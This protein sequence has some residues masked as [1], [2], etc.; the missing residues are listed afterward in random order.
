MS[1]TLLPPLREYALQIDQRRSLGIAEFG[2]HE[3]FPVLWFPGTPGGRRQVP[4]DTRHYARENN[5]RIIC[6]ERPGIGFSTR[7][8]YDAISDFA[9]DIERV[10]EQLDIE[11]CGVVALSGGGPYAL[12]CAHA[13]SSRV[14]A[15]AVF[16]GV[17]PTLGEEAPEGGLTAKALPVEK[18]LTYMKWPLGTVLSRSVKMLHPLADPIVDAI[19]KY[20]PGHETAMIGREDIRAMFIDDILNSSK[21]GLHS[22]LHDIILFNRPWG[23]TLSGIAVPV[24]FWHGEE[25]PMVPPEHAEHMAGLITG[26]GFTICEDAGH[27]E[28]L[29]KTNEALEY[30]LAHARPPK[31]PGAKRA[32]KKAAPAS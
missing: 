25:D 19:V 31:K 6:V 17:A 14:V 13:L 24:H 27:L 5:I 22:I 21:A 9:R 11:R 15:T 12:A 3:G 4:I 23:F 32:S 28:G 16:G 18:W 2:S 26:A 29:N 30:I 1:E 8:L 20:I 7:H 10:V